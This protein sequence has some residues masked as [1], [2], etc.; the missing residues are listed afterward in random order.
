M[1]AWIKRHLATDAAQWH[2]LWSMR[3]VIFWAAFNGALM[4]LWFL[5][6]YVNPLLLFVLTI[7]GYVTIGI[8]RIY[9]Q[10]GLG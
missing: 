3:L 5:Y 4:G 1:I 9:K 10:P 6:G 7:S 2:R 8:A